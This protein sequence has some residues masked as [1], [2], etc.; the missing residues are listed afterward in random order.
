MPVEFVAVVAAAA[1]VL[2]HAPYEQA[3]ADLAVSAQNAEQAVTDAQ[4]VTAAAGSAVAGLVGS[5]AMA[6]FAVLEAEDFAADAP[7]LEAAVAEVYSG[8]EEGLG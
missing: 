3:Q 4:A 6:K 8:A 7:L 1:E 2:V 5:A